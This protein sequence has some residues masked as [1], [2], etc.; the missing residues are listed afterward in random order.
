MK[1]SLLTIEETA[2]LI[3]L[4]GGIAQQHTANATIYSIQSATGEQILINTP[5]DNYLIYID[6]YE[7]LE[8]N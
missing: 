8:R 5:C 1:I 2:D 7:R 4:Q 3:E 6:N